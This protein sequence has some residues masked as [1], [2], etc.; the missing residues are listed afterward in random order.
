MRAP[1]LLLA[2]LVG[3]ACAPPDDEAAVPSLSL[4][5]SPIVGGTLDSGDP[6]VFMLLQEYNNGTQSGCTATLI[7]Q[8]TLVTAA[9][10]VDPRIGNATAVMLWGMNRPSIG[11]ATS[12]DFIPV[13]ETRMH[14]SWNPAVGLEHDIALALLQTAPSVPSVKEWNRASVSA[15]G[16]RPLRAVGYGTTGGGN[17]SGVRRTVDLTFRQVSSTHIWLGDGQGKGVCH[18][19]SGGPSFHTF[20]DGVERLVGIHSFTATEA[21]T[22][23]A[24]I[25]IDAYQSFV[26]QWLAEKEAPTCAEDSRCV[27]GCTP[28]DQDCACAADGQCTAACQNLTKDPDCPVD[29]VA[30]GVCSLFACPTPDIDCVPEG[31][32]CGSELQCSS[33]Q[34]VSDP[35]HPGFYCS[36]PC[37]QNDQCPSGLECTGGVCTYVQLPTVEPGT[38]CTQGQQHCTGGTVCA[39]LTASSTRCLAP[40]VADT[41]CVGP[42]T[43]VDGHNGVKYCADTSRPWVVLQR[44]KLEG[45]APAGCASVGTEPLWALG[46]VAL[47]ALRR[48]RRG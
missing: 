1:L 28:I 25:R 8:R 22:D 33:R 17:G 4:A 39:G 12:S 38:T 45:R 43:C 34:C 19:D 26:S 42:A 13:V 5:R 20:S 18:G 10:C 31:G 37:T 41:D 35:Q 16:G 29:C 30:N 2:V 23:G 9:H 27:P 32:R 11:Q 48:R 47:Q 6:Q 40:C 3:A 7:G 46:L 14:P 44:A 24:D 15:F 36:R 21:C